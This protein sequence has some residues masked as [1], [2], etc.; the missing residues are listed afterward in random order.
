MKQ[1]AWYS[2]FIFLIFTAGC[3][4]E[5]N[6][7]TMTKENI[8]NNPIL[9]K[10]DLPYGVPDFTKISSSD[11]PAAFEYAMAKHLE[12]VEAIANNPD[13]PTIE[14]TLIAME[15]VGQ[16]LGRVSRVFGVLSSANTNEELQ[17]IQEDI[18]PKRAAH[19]DKISLNDNL[20]KRIKTLYDNRDNYDLDS[21]TARLLE[22]QYKDFVLA[23]AELP[24][25]KKEQLMKLNEERATLS[26]QFNNRLL[27]ASEKAAVVIDTEEEL[28]GLSDAEI[29]VAA[30]K[31]TE[32]GHDGKYLL[33]IRNTTQQPQLQA[34]SNRDTREKLFKAS[35]TRAIQG[36]ENDTRDIAIRLSEIRAERSALLG[37]NTYA[38][39]NLQDQMVN[40][41]EDA[42]NFLKN[43]VPASV[44]KANAEAAVIQEKIN[45]TGGDFE[46]EPWDWDFYA[47]Q[48]RKEK[49]D[50]DEEEIRPYFEMWATLED[51]V[52]YAANQLFGITFEPRDNIPVYNEDMRVYEVFNEDGSTVGLFYVDL[53][54]RPNKSGGA[55]MSSIVG[56]STL[57][58]TKPAIYNV[59]NFPKPAE[60]EPA[61]LS[62]DNVE[63]L[64]HEFGHALHGLF[65]NQKYKSLSGTAVA[66]DF[67]EFP[68]QVNEH[69]ALH[70]DILKNYAKHV[71]TGE[72]IPQ[73]L[74]DKI[75]SARSFNQGYAFT[76]LLAAAML[77]M[78]WHTLTT[79]DKVS[80]VQEFSQKALEQTGLYLNTVPPRYR[81]SY[82]SHIFGGGYAAGYYAYLWT[83]MLSHDGYRWFEENGGLTR[84]NGQHFR[85]KVLSKGNTMDYAEMYRAFRGKDPE[86]QPML[87]N[88][89]LLVN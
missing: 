33:T 13:E 22:V 4:T 73:E 65:A 47:E 30:D 63:T 87:E 45:S 6:K 14:N 37:Y 72:V 52:F 67:V 74:I 77:D 57:L 50:L 86:L 16:D 80:D 34:L 19:Y 56:Q 76:E 11:F 43:L 58:G 15:K 18:A 70:P 10:S 61:L 89:G 59:C 64:F 81:S 75:L 8:E 2:L 78:Q 84:E 62:Y 1:L 28:A 7:D 27:K 46:L 23:G 12:E 24:A 40:K 21:E 82:F 38:E 60:G 53:Y 9:I 36:D 69:W 88:K 31:A 49:Y 68:S 42:L 85:D 83:E 55:W 35:W 39:W 54:A 66:R 51:G 41:A 79:E 26:A 3:A 48:V 20:F 17:K 71:E 29:K 44:A 32:A 25:D 5:N